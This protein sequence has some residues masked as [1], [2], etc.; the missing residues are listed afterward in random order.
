MAFGEAMSMDC[1][2]ALMV[3]RAFINK[4]VPTK[5]QATTAEIAAFAFQKAIDLTPFVT[6]RMMSS[7]RVTQGASSNDYSSEKWGSAGDAAAAAI[8]SSPT[9]S[10]T[11]GEPIYIS[12]AAPHAT[13]IE[14]GSP[15]TEAHYI[16]RRV[17]Q[18]VGGKFGRI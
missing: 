15:T 2:D 1:S 9:T 11:L 10:F 7:W 3:L 12:N 17:A 16:T 14:F 4:D 13:Y 6:G 18:S 5:V 8:S